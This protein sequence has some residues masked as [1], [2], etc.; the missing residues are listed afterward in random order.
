MQFIVIF[1]S[2]LFYF[3]VLLFSFRW[4]TK[5]RNIWVNFEWL[6][7]KVFQKCVIQVWPSYYGLKYEWI[8]GT[9][10]RIPNLGLAIW[11]CSSLEF[12]NPWYAQ[13]FWPPMCVRPVLGKNSERTNTN[14]IFREMVSDDILFNFFL[15][16]HSVE[17]Y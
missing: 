13:N 5:S 12:R 4:A 6:E 10:S 7:A 3:T 15:L 14:R 9:L 8:G 17:K 16:M 1:L 11:E 2:R